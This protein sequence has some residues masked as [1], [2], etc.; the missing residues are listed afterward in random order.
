MRD[1]AAA[2]DGAAAEAGKERIEQSCKTC[3]EA[4][5]IDES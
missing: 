4:F 1:A 2:E 3:H 5:D